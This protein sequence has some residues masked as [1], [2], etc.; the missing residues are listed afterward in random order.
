MSVTYQMRQK[1]GSRL[2]QEVECRATGAEIAAYLA[3]VN[4]HPRWFVTWTIPSTNPDNW[5]RPEVGGIL[6]SDGSM[7]DCRHIPAGLFRKERREETPM[8][9][10]E[11]I[12][13]WPAIMEIVQSGEREG[14]SSGYE[15]GMF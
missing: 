1:F 5:R 4:P 9:P 13:G 15:N 14:R 12:Y 10:P 2:R 3:K 7:T 11:H 8:F 6:E